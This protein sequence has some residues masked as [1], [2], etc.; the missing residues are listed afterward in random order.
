MEWTAKLNK[1]ALVLKDKCVM[2]LLDE[3]VLTEDHFLA[4]CS[5]LDVHGEGYQTFRRQF[6]FKGYAYCFTCGL[7]QDQNHNGEGPECH[8]AYVPGQGVKCPFQFAVFR[9]AFAAGYK[10]ELLAGLK[11]E[12]GIPGVTVQEY[13][14]WVTSEEE[15]EGQYHNTI[16]VFLW[17]CE[18]LERRNPRL[19]L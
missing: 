18:R 14:D 16:E 11:K 9:M 15:V 5:N 8:K 17:C 3:G 6:K 7:P 13:L 4:P 2:H 12:L 10:E 1:Y 19:F